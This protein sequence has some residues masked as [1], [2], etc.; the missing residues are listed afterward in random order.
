MLLPGL[1]VMDHGYVTG[2]KLRLIELPDMCT[3]FFCFQKCVLIWRGY[4]T[5]PVRPYLRLCVSLRKPRAVY[6]FGADTL[7]HFW[8]WWWTSEE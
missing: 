8:R 2:M 6:N 4:G 7:L 3:V 5:A 1:H